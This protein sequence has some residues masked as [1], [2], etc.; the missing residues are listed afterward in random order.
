MPAVV[1]SSTNQAS[2]NI[3]TA[4]KENFS[5]PSTQIIETNNSVLEISCDL[6]TDYLIV[7]STHK[8]ERKI[9]TLSVHLPGN[10]G[11]AQ[12]GGKDKT[13]NVAYASKM[14]DILVS[15]KSQVEDLGLDWQVC[16]EVD[17]HGP[18]CSLP[19]IFV[20]I[21]STSKEWGDKTAAEIC[22][23]AIVDGIK[24]QKEYPTIFG[25]G[26]GHY[27]PLFSKIA[28]ES[29]EAVGHILPKYKVDEIDYE[30]FLQGIEKCVEK[31]QYVLIDWK[32]LDSSQRKK[33]I[34]F[35]DNANVPWKAKK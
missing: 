19:V 22:A 6:Q 17:H 33:I 18:T 12:M 11:K 26:G 5:L 27:A 25:V 3:A 28:L 29:S 2:L 24:S 30:T 21:G 23:K 20:E 4:L 1:Y 15:I 35:C 32:G 9:R 31:T 10:W 14:K 16:L 8:S 13:L 7:P 34:T